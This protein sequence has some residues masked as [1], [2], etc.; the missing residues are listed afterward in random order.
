[1]KVLLVEDDISSLQIIEAILQK[2]G[3]EVTACLNAEVAWQ[4]YQQ[5][6]YPLVF[7]DWILPGIDGLTLCRKI[8]KHPKGQQTLVVIITVRQGTEY[9]KQ[10]LD[11]GA[12]DYLAKPLDI[13]LF[14]V[15]LTIIE[16]QVKNLL[17]RTQ[18]EKNLAAA[19]S[20]LEK[21]HDNILSMLNRLRTG[22]I[23]I[24]KAGKISFISAT[25]QQLCGMTEID[26]LGQDWLKIFA[27]S[28]TT[29]KP[30]KDLLKTSSEKKEKLSLELILP[31][32]Q[33]SYIDV[34]IQNHL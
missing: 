10:I 9:L 26:L 16:R 4:L 8:R 30:L 3:H 33:T 17:L 15:R 14:I 28:K 6:Q 34:E 19:L 20:E 12:D 5:N 25:A 29:L 23:I 2:Q 31:N 32:K 22:T 24:D 13:D 27:L 1:M 7:S 18:S 11:A 21:N